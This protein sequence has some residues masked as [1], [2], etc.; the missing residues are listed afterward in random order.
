MNWQETVMRNMEI[1]HAIYNAEPKRL[2]DNFLLDKYLKQFQAVANAQAEISF[3]AGQESVIPIGEIKQGLKDISEGKVVPLS[4]V[5]QE[6]KAQDTE[7]REKILAIERC[8][9]DSERCLSDIE[10]PLEYTDA[11]PCA[12][13]RTTQLLAL[14]GNVK[15]KG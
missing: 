2:I 7:L 11:D 13:C 10:C 14:F 12:E 6:S 1:Q 15:K 5:M 3:K 9:S 8:L 4:Q